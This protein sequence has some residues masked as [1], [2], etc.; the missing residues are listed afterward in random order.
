MTSEDQTETMRTRSQRRRWSW[1]GPLVAL[2]VLLPWSAWPSPAPAADGGKDPPAT[3]AVPLRPAPRGRNAGS[4]DARVRSLSKALDLDQQQ[5][6]GLRRVL[7]AQREE[8]LAVWAD[9]SQPAAARVKA[10]EFISRRTADRIR[11]LLTEQQRARY[12]PPAQPQQASSPRPGLETWM[13]P[14]RTMSSRLE[15]RREAR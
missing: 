14:A 10:T 12:N 11:A 2:A 7:V 1:A 5:Q 6:T 13:D 9:E 15:P 3:G 8:T 4:L